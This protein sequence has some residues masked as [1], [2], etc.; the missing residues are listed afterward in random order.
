[1]RRPSGRPDGYDV[2][3]YRRGARATYDLPAEAVEQIRLARRMWNAIVQRHRDLD[4]QCQAVKAA[5]RM[6][7]PTIRC[8]ATICV[9]GWGWARP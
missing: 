5:G 1:M 6:G 9:C 2:A 7:G 8:G 3:A 4:E